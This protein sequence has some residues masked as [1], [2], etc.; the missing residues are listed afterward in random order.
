MRGFFITCSQRMESR[1]V[2]ESI[3]LLDR[4]KEEYFDETLLNSKGNTVNE[5]GSFVSTEDSLS[6][7]IANL[8]KAEMKPFVSVPLDNVKN[9]IFIRSNMPELSPTRILEDILSRHDL[10]SKLGMRY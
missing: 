7:E 10:L 8:R 1:C 3:Q 5:S 6:S 4:W 2:T 9:L